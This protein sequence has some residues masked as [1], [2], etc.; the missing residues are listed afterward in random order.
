M[1]TMTVSA[2]LP[3]RS[4]VSCV[5]AV[6]RAVPTRQPARQAT[7]AARQPATQPRRAPTRLTRR[8]RLAVT[9]AMVAVS[10]GVLGLVQPQALALGRSDGP[11]T[12]RI[13]VRPGETLWA[14]ADRV[15][16]NADPRSTIARLESMNHL[17]SSTVPAGSVL[18]VP[19]T[20]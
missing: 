11:A 14:I 17:E 18:L 2:A 15:A 9:L 4:H 20:R 8:G 16:P 13:T 7:Q 5:T 3:Q 1:S 12:M 6:P 19:V 10:T